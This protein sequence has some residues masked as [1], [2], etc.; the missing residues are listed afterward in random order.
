MRA[1]PGFALALAAAAVA[2]AFL[3]AAPG[4]SFYVSDESGMAFE[5]IPE[6][7]LRDFEW[8]LEVSVSPG[9]EE[10]TLR[11]KSGEA[12][13]RWSYSFGDNGRV[14]ALKY[15]EK[16]ELARIER[17]DGSGRLVAEERYSDGKAFERVDYRYESGRLVKAI[18]FGPMENV[19]STDVYRYAMNGSLRE[20]T[21][22]Y[23]DG[24]TAS[25][26]AEQVDGKLLRAW[27]RA[28]DRTNVRFY[29]RDGAL[30]GIE[31]WGGNEPIS[32]EERAKRGGEGKDVV[33]DLKRKA[34]IEREYD[35]KGRLV[36]ESVFEGETLSSLTEYAWNGAGKLDGKTLYSGGDRE[37]V[38]YA[39][40][41]EG[42][43]ET[44]EHRL[45]GELVKIVR[46]SGANASWT[47]LYHE[48][49]L[50]VRYYEE[51]GRKRVEEIIR[52]GE[53]ARRREFP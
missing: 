46:P 2:A 31:A 48:G 51:D 18:A 47:E 41:A 34:R 26:G 5:E 14:A 4:G 6:F 28:A 3:A 42:K 53:V 10:R 15:Y 1:R 52:D 36:R 11:S 49:E 25:A 50:A 12:E 22:T 37:D 44:E 27:E 7:R 20:M 24:S 17:F 16:G 35:A 30:A 40:D 38:S 8:T 43:L 39:Y 33:A 29:G 13:K 21:R 45:N 23:A 19:I 9:A 32:I